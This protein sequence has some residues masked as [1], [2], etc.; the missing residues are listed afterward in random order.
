MQKLPICPQNNVNT[1]LDTGYRCSVLWNH[2]KFCQWYNERFVRLY[3]YLSSERLIKIVYEGCAFVK[4]FYQD[5][6]QIDFLS[7]DLVPFDLIGFMRNNLE[8]GKYI[9]ISLDEIFIEDKF[10][11][12]KQHFIHPTLIY[13]HNDDEGI[14][15]AIG[16]NK[17][18][19]FSYI[20]MSYSE[21]Y[22]SFQSYMALQTRGSADT[23][24]ELLTIRQRFNEYKY[25]P[26]RFKEEISDYFYGMRFDTNVY[27]WHDPKYDFAFEFGMNI[28][29][30]IRESLNNH[31]V[32]PVD[33]RAFHLLAEHKRGLLEKVLFYINYTNN[34]KLGSV[35]EGLNELVKIS[36]I[37]RKKY[38]MCATKLDANKEYFLDAVT[39]LAVKEQGVL[40][41]LLDQ[42]QC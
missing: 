2:P 24:I 19:N 33:Y 15:Y 29:D 12:K 6:L 27:P 35:M 38:L 3:S 28:Y 36:E 10:Y 17:K 22:E 41:M 16:F 1:Y 40:K 26:F 8:N 9:I 42:M 23:A 34:Q 25:D 30:S 4:Y 21:V 32:E 37:A 11:Y 5:A 13:G 20:S 7:K 31:L 18:L 14:F 39:S